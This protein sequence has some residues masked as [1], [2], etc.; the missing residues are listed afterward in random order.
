MSKEKKSV[1]EIKEI[2]SELIHDLRHEIYMDNFS[3]ASFIMDA[4]D[5]S[6]QALREVEA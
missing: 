5:I 2:I 6:L 3:K 4:I 1:T